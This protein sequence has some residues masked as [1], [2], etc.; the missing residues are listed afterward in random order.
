MEKLG[1]IVPFL[2]DSLK[3]AGEFSIEDFPQ[4]RKARDALDDAEN[5]LSSIQSDI[6]SHKSGL[7]K[8]YWHNDVFRSLDGSCISTEAGEYTYELCWLASA[9]QKSRKNNAHVGL[10]NFEK[11]DSETVLD[12]SLAYPGKLV[13][14]EKLVLQYTNGQYCWNGPNRSTKVIVECGEEN[15]IL[16]VWETEKCVY[17]MRVSSPV[18]C[19]VDD[20]ASAAKGQPSQAAKDE[21]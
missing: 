21:L 5:A 9:S 7:V 11:F 1:S 20:N 16:K 19:E 18:V 17:S 13:Q 12:A 10:G 2:T 8:D 14:N 3:S 6:D 4:V 15:R